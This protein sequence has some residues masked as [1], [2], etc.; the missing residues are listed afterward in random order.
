MSVDRDQGAHFYRTD[1]QIHSPRDLNW[2]GCK[3][4]SPEGRL[5]YSRKFI[6]KCREL[7]IQAVGITDHNDVCFVKYFQVA[8]QERPDVSGVPSWD[9]IVPHPQDQDPIVFPGIE[10]NIQRLCQAIILLDA[11]ADPTMHSLLLEALNIGNTHPDEEQSGPIVKQIDFK[12]FEDLENSLNTYSSGALQ[13]KF[14]ILP[15]V[16]KDGSYL[17]LL[18]HGFY[19]EYARMPCVGGYI[20]HDLS[21]HNKMSVLNGKAREYGYKAIA[22]FQTTDLRRDD[23]TDLG[24]RSTWVKIAA[25]TAEALRQACLARASRVTQEQ[26]KLPQ[27][28]IHKIEVSDSKFLGPID[29]DLNPQ[30]NA[31][32]GGRGT[33]KTTVL[34]YI[35]HAMQDQPVADT[36]YDEFNLKR[37][38]IIETVTDCRGT[39]KVHWLKNSVRHIVC[40]NTAD[41]RLTLSIDEG[42]YQEIDPDELRKILPIQ[43]YSQ[44]QLS[45]VGT[46]IQELQRFIEQP[47]REKL[48][49]CNHTIENKRQ[50]MRNVY[51]VLCEHNTK[52]K[53]LRGTETRL[54]SM[55]RQADSVRKTLTQVTPELATALNEHPLRLAEKEQIA[56]IRAD[57]REAT[58][59]LAGVIR[60]LNSLPRDIS[61]EEDLPQKASIEHIYSKTQN[62]VAQTKHKLETINSEWHSSQTDI[63]KDIGDWSSEDGRHSAEY[64][65]AQEEAQESKKKLEKLK[66]LHTQAATLQK[67]IA[68][69]KGDIEKHNKAKAEFDRAW[70]A[71]IEEHTK[72]GD[73][74]ED[75]CNDLARKSEGEIKAKL[76]RGADIEGPMEKLK[77]ALHGCNITQDRWEDIQLRLEGHAKSPAKGWMEVMEKLKTLAEMEENDITQGASL[78]EITDWDLTENMRRRII[79]RFK[80]V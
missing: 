16:G 63:E 33:G 68:Q 2:T 5:D 53:Q 65:K 18:R 38:H 59:S 52:L 30:Y 43:A 36:S 40:L 61:V 11:H 73:L 28:Y 51:S 48:D 12:S 42:E 72:R 9:S 57:L 49:E 17:T 6:A 13:G 77:S 76:F 80:S 8:A 26:P 34:E 22:V 23:F 66:E 37:K 50:E 41:S 46:R 55:N 27:M 60:I 20:E 47:I 24:K 74:L 71:W 10:V 78:P 75:V 7:G 15:H 54:A 1:F 44:K 79:Q 21:E 69:L 25:P 67:N 19:K 39:I 45:G 29:L 35:R 58:D 31:L 14:I 70:G 62:L 56:S 64:S 3:P 32:I 4:V